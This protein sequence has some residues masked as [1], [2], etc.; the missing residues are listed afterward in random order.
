MSTSTLTPD[1]TNF[2]TLVAQVADRA[3]ARLPECNGR[4]EKAVKLVLMQDVRPLA[5]GAVEVGSSSDPLLTHLVSGKSC[6]CQDFQY[7]K[8]PEGYCAHRLAAAMLQRVQELQAAQPEPEP[9]PD[10]EPDLETPKKPGLDS[11]FWVTISGK[12]FVRFEGLL[13][14]ANEQG[15][16][17]L[18]TTVVTVTPDFAVCQAIARFKDG[19]VFTDVGDATPSNVT[20]HIAPHFVRMSATRASARALRRALNINEA[21]VEELGDLESLKAA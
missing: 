15:L 12:K 9:E 2:R 16:V 13:T 4:V 20:K 8:A 11:R 19:R 14:L 7:G 5:D 1:R 10:P 6:D 17:E 3:K 18:S 21:A